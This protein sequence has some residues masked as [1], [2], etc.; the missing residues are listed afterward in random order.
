MKALILGGAGFIGF[1][2]AKSLSD[3]GNQ[4]T[5]CDN[6]SRGRN[7]DSLKQLV[8]RGNINFVEA[9]IIRKNALTK[10]GNRFDI[11]YHLAAINGTRYFYEIPYQVLRVNIMSLINVLDWLAGVECSKLVW[12]S[13]SETYAGTSTFVDIPLPTPEN[14]PLVISDVYNPRFSYAGSKIAGEL[15]C[16]NFAKTC[17]LNVTVVRPGNVYGPRMGY[18]HVIPEFI[19]RIIKREEPF[20]VYG[21]NQTRSF[22][23][24]R[25]FVQGIKLIGESSKTDRKIIN[26]GSDKEEIR[27]KDLAAKMF[28]LFNYHPTME[29]LPAPEGS[30]ER[31]CC[32]TGTAK[33]LVGYEPQVSLD[34][35]LRITYDWYLSQSAS[36]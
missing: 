9:D 32:D 4:V 20:R 13:S 21:G 5:I 24:I 36:K 3:E 2:L 16:L 18:E 23:F 35:G 22:C 19:M 26:L 27:M 11:V 34:A 17:G 1:H 14:I 10:L 6:L 30:V 12:T 31:R 28:D 15:L 29:I 7:D 8:S 25:D 33:T